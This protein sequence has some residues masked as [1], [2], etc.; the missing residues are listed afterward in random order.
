MVLFLAIFAW[1]EDG[2]MS[3]AGHVQHRD[4]TVRPCCP[5]PQC[6]SFNIKIHKG[7]TGRC[8][9]CGAPFAIADVRKALTHR[10]PAKWTPQ[11]PKKPGSG[12]FPEPCRERK[13]EP[14]T[15]DMM[16]HAR[17]CMTSRHG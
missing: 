3:T 8:S 17:L 13:F 14:L 10:G 15:Y 2:L 5:E 6:R 16:A 12:V 7:G 4:S 11:R 9:M 1:I